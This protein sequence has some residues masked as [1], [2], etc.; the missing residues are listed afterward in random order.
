MRNSNDANRFKKKKTIRRVQY[1]FSIRG[2]FSSQSHHENLNTSIWP[3]FEVWQLITLRSLKFVQ[4]LYVWTLNLKKKKRVFFSKKSRDP[5]IS[6]HLIVKATFGPFHL[7]KT[8]YNAIAKKW[9]I[10]SEKWMS[11]FLWFFL[12]TVIIIVIHW[13]QHFWAKFI[14]IIIF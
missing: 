5:A 13:I 10:I 7:I 1:I 14:R 12:L 9:S 3:I 4:I 8:V 6:F 2:L 11:L